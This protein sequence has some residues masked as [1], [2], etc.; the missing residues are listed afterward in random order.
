IPRDLPRFCEARVVND[1]ADMLRS[2]LFTLAAL[3]F[4]AC[5]SEPS[6]STTDAGTDASCA[7]LPCPSN[8]PWSPAACRCVAP[9]AGP[10]A[11]IHASDYDGS[12]KTV[13]DCVAIVEGPVCGCSCPNAAIN[14]SDLA[15]EEADFQREHAKCAPDGPTCGGACYEHRLRC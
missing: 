7:P 9:D 8:A 12:C 6:S 1:L 3:A 2:V 10:S 5:S 11:P 13:D 14:K 15:R 4:A